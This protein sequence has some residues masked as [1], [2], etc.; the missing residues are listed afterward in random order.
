MT[1]STLL[2]EL[3]ALSAQRTPLAIALT[4]GASSMSYGDLR[5]SVTQ[6]VS[7]LMGLGLGRN[8]RLAI[9]LEKRF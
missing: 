2:P 3:I 9:Y 6:F 7:G 5:A 4:H 1:E 8:E